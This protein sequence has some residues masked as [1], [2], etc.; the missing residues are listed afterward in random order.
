MKPQKDSNTILD[1][2]G[3]YWSYNTP[4]QVFTRTGTQFRCRNFCKNSN[5]SGFQANLG[6]QTKTLQK[7]GLNLR[8]GS[9]KQ[10]AKSL[11]SRTSVLIISYPKK[12][13]AHRHI[14]IKTRNLDFLGIFSAGCDKWNF[15]HTLLCLWVAILVSLGCPHH[16]LN[17]FGPYASIRAV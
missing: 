16:V 9:P 11:G 1:L 12:V 7:W 6:S 17:H 4:K 3:R 10:F 5:F 2:K 14:E 8:N 13:C 15:V